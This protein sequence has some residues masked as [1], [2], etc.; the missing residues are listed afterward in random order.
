MATDLTGK[1][2]N[3]IQLTFD[4]G[5]VLGT[6]SDDVL[7][8]TNYFS[9]TVANGTGANQAD[10]VFR[11]Q[12]TLALS[13]SE[14]LDLAGSLTD[15]YGATIT[16]ARVKMIYVKAASTNGGNIIIGGAAA[17]TFVG[18]FS[19][20]SDKVELA[21]G[22]MYQVTAPDATGWAVTA[23]TADILKVENDDGA[24][25]GTYDIIIVGASA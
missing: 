24:A 10:L 1:I 14:D 21:A 9:W 18:S 17:N 7:D 4:A 6:T 25:V 12:R 8:S 22:Q 16:F 2:R 15:A 20:A 11:G 5:S 13:T 3:S 19:D 23:G